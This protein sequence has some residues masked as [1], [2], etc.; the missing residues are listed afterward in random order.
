MEAANIVMLK[1]LYHTKIAKEY[2]EDTA[3][4][5]T[6]M[7]KHTVN[8]FANKCEFIIDNVRHRL[9]AETLKRFDS[10]TR[11]ALFIDAIETEILSFNDKQRDILETIV[12]LIAKGE[13]IQIIND[14][15]PA[16]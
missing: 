7:Q 15:L 8:M 6:G 16:V 5:L 1:A 4:H 3:K 10:E 11:D 2:F 12:S 9:P 14:E 13:S